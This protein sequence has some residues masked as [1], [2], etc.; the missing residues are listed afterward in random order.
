LTDA[1]ARIAKDGA[2]ITN[3]F[4][5]PA[6]HPALRLEKESRDGFYTAMRQLHLDADPPRP[7]LCRPPNPVA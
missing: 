2:I 6:L 7:G 3:Q 5:L 1:Q 4:G